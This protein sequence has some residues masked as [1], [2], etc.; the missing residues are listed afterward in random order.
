MASENPDDWDRARDG[1]VK[2]YLQRFGKQND[3]RTEKVRKWAEDYD[4]RRFEE[5]LDRHVRHV[6]FQ[7]GL[8]VEA[9]T[10]AEK[11]A[12]QAAEAEHDGDLEAAARLWQQARGED[13][14][15]RVGL[16]AGRHL[17]MFDAID[18][19]YKQL[20]VLR[21]EVRQFR[22]EPQLE[23][24]RALAF[25]A[26]RQER[27]GDRAGAR[28]RYEQLREAAGKEGPS[29]RFWSLFAADASQRLKAS[30]TAKPQEDK[31]RISLIQDTVEKVQKALA[32]PGAVLLDL[33]ATAHDVAVLYEK[34]PDLAAAAEQA[35]KL[36]AQIDARLPPQR[37]N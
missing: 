1:L 13:S 32:Q 33:R 26:V 12:F 37:G 17:A 10:G 8:A 11:L 22:T 9:Q 28:R 6:R 21:Q 4:V 30:L 35:R 24:L 23:P 7:R 14:E 36:V 5:L 34:D 31:A 3:A 19:Q 2:E 16:V 25:L 18:A 29:Q 15:G 27:L 20:E